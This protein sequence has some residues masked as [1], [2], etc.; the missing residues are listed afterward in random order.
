MSTTITC[1]LT[2][3]LSCMYT[4]SLFTLPLFILALHIQQQRITTINMNAIRMIPDT[5]AIIAMMY[6][7]L[8]L[9]LRRETIACVCVC[10]CDCIPCIS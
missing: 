5:P 3:R 9:N 8:R 6:V 1:I 4:L 7:M 10:V 2:H